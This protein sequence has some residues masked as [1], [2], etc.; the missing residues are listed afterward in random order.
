MKISCRE[1]CHVI[2]YKNTK[3]VKIIIISIHKMKVNLANVKEN[4]SIGLGI[5]GYFIK[6]ILLGYFIKNIRID[7]NLAN[8]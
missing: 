5:F 2:Q 1:I 3:I 8:W 6:N 7:Y 4:Y